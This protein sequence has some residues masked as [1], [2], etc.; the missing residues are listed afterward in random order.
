M[1][2]IG[3]IKHLIDKILKITNKIIIVDHDVG[4]F[5][6]Y[7]NLNIKRDLAELSP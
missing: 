2:F 5:I 3:F 1:L 4:K 6:E 7:K